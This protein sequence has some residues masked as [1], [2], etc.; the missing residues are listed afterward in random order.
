MRWG[1]DWIKIFHGSHENDE[2]ICHRDSLIIGSFETQ[3][4]NRC[5]VK[6][7]LPWLN[8]C[9]LRRM[10]LNKYWKNV[11]LLFFILDIWFTTFEMFSWILRYFYDRYAVNPTTNSGL[12]FVDLNGAINLPWQFLESVIVFVSIYWKSIP[13]F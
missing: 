1:F 3:N 12:E 7:S 8:R 5:I 11:Q 13:I 10:L 2:H 6:L 9:I 4:L